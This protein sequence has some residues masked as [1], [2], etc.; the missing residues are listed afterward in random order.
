[1]A[2]MEG[3]AP[4]RMLLLMAVVLLVILLLLLVLLL[5]VLPLL[6]PLLLLL[7]PLLLPPLLLLLL[8]LLAPPSTDPT[9]PFS[10]GGGDGGELRVRVDLASDSTD[11]AVAATQNRVAPSLCAPR[12]G[13]KAPS[14]AKPST[15]PSAVAMI[16]ASSGGSGDGAPVA[17]TRA[18][19]APQAQKRRCERSRRHA[20]TQGARSASVKPAISPITL[21]RTSAAHLTAAGKSVF[22]EADA[23]A[24]AACALASCV[25]AVGRKSKSVSDARPV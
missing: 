12:V 1:V 22:S 8:L 15:T 21:A 23:A 6:P 13:P 16:F 2:A 14:A 20:P 25:R 4:R 11:S 18:L 7:P 9:S 19:A 10:L 17:S 3:G 5:L 24:R